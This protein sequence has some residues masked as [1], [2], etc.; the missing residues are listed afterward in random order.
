MKVFCALLVLVAVLGCAQ[1][2]RIG[3][4]KQ[5]MNHRTP[6]YLR[7][8]ASSSSE[9]FIVG[10]I[11]ANI[12]D[13]PHHLALLER[14]RYMCGASI[15]STTYSLSAAHCLDAGAPP[16]IISLWGGSTSRLTGGHIF[17]VRR[18][19]LHPQY[20]D[21]TLDFDVALMEVDRRLEGFPNLTPIAL[22]PAC[23]TACCGVCA[24]TSI[25]V[26]GWGATETGSLPVNLLQITKSIVTN[27]VCARAWGSSITSRMFCTLVENGIDSCNGDSGGAIV[28]MDRNLQVGLVSF[29]SEVCGDGSG[30]AVYARIEDPQIRNWIRQISEV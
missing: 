15:I 14:G 3:V 9:S 4:A 26:A 5:R 12:A 7:Q 24:P 2:G 1:S 8:R 13:F 16:S 21:W 30:P 29:G 10:G 28:N 17:P 19:F 25:R 22:P 23:S 20:N 11:P 6:F 18:Y 27:T